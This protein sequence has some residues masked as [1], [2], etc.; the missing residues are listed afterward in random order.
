L[1][2]KDIS[3]LGRA[4]QGVRIMRLNANDKVVS[5]ALVEKLEN[6]EEEETVG[7]TTSQTTTKADK[8]ARQAKQ[9]AAERPKGRS[10]S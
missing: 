4:T 8:P 2:L 10:R 6:G 7:T 9:Q 1:G 3:S 5:L